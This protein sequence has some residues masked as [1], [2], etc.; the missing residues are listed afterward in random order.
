MAKQL[1]DAPL[2]NLEAAAFCSQMAMILRSGISSPEGISLLL[3]DSS[4]ESERRVLSS[5]L[6]KIQQGGSFSEALKETQVFPDY[7]IRM[8]RL[9]EET[10]TLDEVMESL[11]EHYVREDSLSQTVRNALAYPL[12]MIGMMIV[13]IV[14]LITKVMPVFNQVFIQL[15]QEMTG[16]SLA[17]LRLGRLLSRY[18]A[19]FVGLMAILVLFAL[20]LSRS[21]KGR[22]LLRNMGYRFSYTREI[23]EK[24]AVCRFADGMALTLRSGLSPEQGLELAGALPEDPHF[25][26]KLQLCRRL[27]AEGS[28]LADAL[29]QA[30]VFTGVYARMATIAERSGTMDEVMSHM[31]DQYADEADSRVNELIAAL[32]PTLVILL[33]VIAGAILFSV[34]LPL[35]SIMAGL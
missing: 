5:I 10:G 7:L 27:I 14:L 35:L 30:K 18:A 16:F 2:S 12:I 31:A 29:R 9:G 33:S 15:G 22:S 3:E 25:Q 17:V 28:S 19:V 6:V 34:M 1:H 24:T 13:I 26:E 32:E 4:D 21:K 20:Y 8:I 23:Y 11:G